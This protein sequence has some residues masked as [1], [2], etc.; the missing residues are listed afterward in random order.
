M[1]RSGIKTFFKK[2]IHHKAAAVALVL[3]FLEL[4]AIL[5]LPGALHLDAVT[6]DFLNMAKGPSAEHIW[7]TDEIGRDIF[8]RVL[9]GGRISLI[10]GICSTALSIAIGLPLGVVAG[11]YQGAV[12]NFIM[13]LADMFM[14]FPPMVLSLVLVTVLEPSMWTVI[15][16]IGF[17]GWTRPCK[18]L[19]GSVMATKGREYV[20]VAVTLGYSNRKILMKYV[21]PNSLS[22]LWVSLAFMISSAII[23]ESSLS[24]L[25]AGIQPPQSSW[26][27]LI[28]AAQQFDVLTTKVWMWIPACIV[29]LITVVCINLIG[30]GI[31]DALD[32]KMRR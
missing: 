7:G 24:F 16:A 9:Y 8:A 26:G 27:N 5:I 30:E 25:G 6:S 32:P 1:K 28:Y 19:Y 18:L 17:L 10:V 4:A 15:F 29:L 22:P 12:G 20:E 3:F 31:R 21:I 14:S 2:F 23:T 13:R 11:Y